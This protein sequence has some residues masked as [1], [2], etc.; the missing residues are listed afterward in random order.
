MLLT[1]PDATF[2]IRSDGTVLDRGE[3]IDVDS[4]ARRGDRLVWVHDGVE[5]TAPLP[6]R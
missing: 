2:E 4:L 6:D 5:R 3:G 1:S